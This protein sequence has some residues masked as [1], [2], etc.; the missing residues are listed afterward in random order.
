M[1]DTRL[2]PKDD[3]DKAAEK[4]ELAKKKAGD[5]EKARREHER[6]LFEKYSDMKLF[7]SWERIHGGK[8]PEPG[9]E[10]PRIG[11]QH[12][13]T[14]TFKRE[15]GI[16]KIKHNE[17]MI[18]IG[19]TDLVICADADGGLTVL[20]TPSTSAERKLC[21]DA[22]IRD[23]QGRGIDT[24]EL[25]FPKL[26]GGSVSLTHILEILEVAK[27]RGVVIE[28]DAPTQQLIL[29]SL[30]SSEKEEDLSQPIRYIF[31]K[32]KSQLAQE[33]LALQTELKRDRLADTKY[34][35]KTNIVTAEMNKHDLNK[36]MSELKKNIELHA[37]P[38]EILEG[39]E[40]AMNK[41][42]KVR[43]TISQH[44]QTEN[45]NKGLRA[46]Y[47]DILETTKEEFRNLETLRATNFPE[48]DL[49]EGHAGPATELAAFLEDP[50]MK[51]RWEKIK[52]DIK[53]EVN[54]S[55]GLAPETQLMAKNTDTEALKTTDIPKDTIVLNYF[56]NQLVAHQLAEDGS[57]QKTTLN[58]T[59]EEITTLGFPEFGSG[60]SLTRRTGDMPSDLMN[61]VA[62]QL[63]LNSQTLNFFS[64]DIDQ[65][66]QQKEWDKKTIG[67]L[68]TAYSEFEKNLSNFE[69]EIKH[70][71]DESKKPGS[72]NE[73]VNTNRQIKNV[74]DRFE[75]MNNELVNMNKVLRNMQIEV[76]QTGDPGTCT[77]Y[78]TN[79]ENL[80]TNLE[81]SQETSHTVLKAYEGF[82]LSSPG[83]T[84]KAKN[85][86]L[87]QYLIKEYQTQL[88]EAEK[89][90][91]HIEDKV[92][93]ILINKEEED[94]KA[95]LRR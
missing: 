3:K 75:A 19:G 67:G 24:L 21:T 2:D 8:L 73:F 29:Q 63:G 80:K 79:L 61:K 42:H 90:I 62:H 51:K 46:Y 68:A 91:A 5:D 52:A 23:Y 84:R 94:R 92:N 41:I 64:K 81:A 57:I 27:A 16:Y 58:L 71:Q 48:I 86:P 54:L 25:S 88:K 36:G 69:K 7:Y 82:K 44:L 6:S 70:Y 30:G 65:E 78:K 9:E 33:I 18:K 55:L 85:D 38:K 32:P 49:L 12:D 13:G 15:E 53:A 89:N 47:K 77:L 43:D 4:A 1:A 93:E 87:H 14:Y 72:G 31:D 66:L 20:N 45:N 50:Q 95:G 11:L 74:L 59:D 56:N 28:F 83:W 34:H 22:L 37:S 17:K 35:N 60:V 10:N 39:M 40:N 76:A 26:K